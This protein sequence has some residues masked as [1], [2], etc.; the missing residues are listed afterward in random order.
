MVTR[1]LEAHTL[2]TEL[3]GEGLVDRGTIGGG[4]D[5]DLC[6]L[7]GSWLFRASAALANTDAPISRPATAARENRLFIHF[8]CDSLIDRS[9]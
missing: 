6:L 7:G 4:N 1:R 8:S 5:E 2:D 9:L 3:D